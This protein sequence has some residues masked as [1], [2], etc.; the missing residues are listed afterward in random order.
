VALSGIS[1]D[2]EQVAQQINHQQLTF[3]LVYMT[4]ALGY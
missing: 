4:T 1:E 2:A 3:E